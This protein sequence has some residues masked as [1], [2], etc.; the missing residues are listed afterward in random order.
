MAFVAHVY[1]SDGTKANRERP[2]QPQN[3]DANV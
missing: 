2:M 1:D 3:M